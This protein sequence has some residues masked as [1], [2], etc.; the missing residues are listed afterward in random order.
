M[1][2]TD[3]QLKTLQ[4]YLHE[5]LV[6]REAYE[7]IYDHILTALEDQPGNISYQD[8]INNIIR[9]DFGDP[10]NLLKV[11]KGIKEGLVNDAI[12]KYFAYLKSYFTFPGIFYTI[13]G[14]MASY[15]FFSYSAFSP[16]IIFWIFAFLV[17]APSVIWLMRLYNTGYI[18]DTTR[19]SARDKLFETFTGVPIRIGLIPMAFINL[20]DYKIWQ[21]NNYYFITL[22][23]VIGVVY[24]LAL[25]RLYKDE[26]NNAPAI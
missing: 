21:E 13:T 9:N 24:N 7:E 10:K 3:E 20:T 14:V 2:P 19:K 11:E 16:G 12:R 8:A 1:K 23:F 18:L 25:Y 26:F 15:Y 6:Y 5:T 22:F 17:I 4:D